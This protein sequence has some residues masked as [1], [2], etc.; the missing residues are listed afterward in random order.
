MDKVLFID[1]HNFIW[2]ANIT[3]GG[4]VKHEPVVPS[5]ISNGITICACK[6]PWNLEQNFC[7]G[8]KY[9]IIFNFFRNLRPI[10]EQFVPDKCFFVLEGHPKFRYDL[11]GDYKANRIIKHA[12]KQEDQ[13]RFFRNRDIIVSL[14]PHTPITLAKAA[15]YEA[16]DVVASLCDN[17]KTEDL[18]IVSTDTD[19]IQLLQLG[20]ANLQIYNPIKKIDMEAPPYPYVGWKC[21]NGD[22]SDNI[23]KLLTPKKALDTINNPEL[24]KQFLSVEENRANFNINRQLIEFGKVPEEE[25]E[26]QEGQRNFQFLYDAFAQMKFETIIRKDAWTR[27][28]KT[29]DCIKY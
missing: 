20:Y 2:R 16:D 22:K 19:Y 8:E 7:Y 18:A 24:L 9:N 23:P 15:N 3:F 27:Y 28:I 4:P 14:L 29:F 5:N 6:A 1:G 13:T 21:L 12:A 25:I 10:I 11:Y 26:L 17:M